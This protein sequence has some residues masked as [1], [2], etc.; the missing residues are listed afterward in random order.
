M[1]VIFNKDSSEAEWNL[2]L[3]EF[4]Q[5][6]I[7]NI[8]SYNVEKTVTI[9]DNSVRY[10]L[11]LK[12]DV[13][14]DLPIALQFG[15][16]RDQGFRLFGRPLIKFFLFYYPGADVSNPYNEYLYN[17]SLWKYA[18]NPI[19]KFTSRLKI[20]RWIKWLS[21]RYSTKMK[22]ATKENRAVDMKLAGFVEMLIRQVGNRSD[23]QEV[24]NIKV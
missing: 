7:D 12:D 1:P 11:S 19:M 17:S 15:V 22:I 24:L 9:R 18:Y 10:H 2:K 13:V 5:S 4:L 21:F 14:G 20:F 23:F 3:V 8:S 16:A 6:I